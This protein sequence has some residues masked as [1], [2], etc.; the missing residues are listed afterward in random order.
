MDRGWDESNH[1]RDLLI[2]FFSKSPYDEHLQKGRLLRAVPALHVRRRQ[3]TPSI[4]EPGEQRSAATAQTEKMYTP[5][6]E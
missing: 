4:Q 1:V 3:E 2:I 5:A 6:G